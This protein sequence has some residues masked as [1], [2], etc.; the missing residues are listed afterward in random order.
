MSGG[1]DSSVAAYLMKQ[2][3]YD[4]TGITLKLFGQNSSDA[5]DAQSVARLLNIPH[6]VIDLSE[7]FEKCVVK[8]FIDVYQSGATPNPCVDCNRH[9]KFG[10]LFDYM[11]EH[12][13]DI[14]ATGHYARVG[15]DTDSARF[16]LK[17][18]LDDKKDQSYVLYSLTQEKL[19][20]ILFPLGSLTKNEIR[21]IAVG[22]GFS[23]A[24]KRD[25]QDIC[26]V[27]DGD[28]AGFIERYLSTGFTPGNFIDKHG[29]VLGR[30]RG[31]IHYTTGQRKGLGLAL[32]EPMYVLSK[33]TQANTVTLCR[34]DELYTSSLDAVEFNWIFYGGTYPGSSVSIRAKARVRYN[35]REQWA[36]VTP[37]AAGSVHIEFDEPQRAIT[38]GQAVVL[39]DGDTVLGGGTIKPRTK[40][41]HPE[42]K[43]TNH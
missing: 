37:T 34:D 7:S 31:L 32:P 26:F 28:Y 36:T 19:K 15:Y 35:S 4:C 22:Q 24:N 42:R 33:D 6:H 38:N 41:L 43:P 1:V 9:I 11:K 23:N 13:A 18:A 8:R 14:I 39:Y 30:H 10:K 21:V 3:G 40:I 2:Q 12:G 20:H 17:K 25:S 29:N 27:P 16:M 5:E